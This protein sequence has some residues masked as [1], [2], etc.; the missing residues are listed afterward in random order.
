M[1]IELVEKSYGGTFPKALSLNSGA[2]KA[3]DLNSLSIISFSLMICLI[4]SRQSG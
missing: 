2:N 4:S 1:N 3:Y